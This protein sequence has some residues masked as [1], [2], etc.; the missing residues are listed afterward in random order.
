[1]TKET[2]DANQVINELRVLINNLQYENVLLKVQLNNQK[3]K[4]NQN[5]AK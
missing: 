2:I 1:M 4:E 3:E 5:K